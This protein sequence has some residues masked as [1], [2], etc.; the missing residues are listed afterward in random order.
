MVVQLAS[1]LEIQPNRFTDVTVRD[2]ALYCFWSPRKGG[3][4]CVYVCD[5]QPYKKTS[6]VELC[7]SCQLSV[8]G[9]YKKNKL[10]GRTF[11]MTECLM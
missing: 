7:V 1:H 3:G 11:Q 4:G 8:S 6:R 10:I 5:C 2:S 9:N